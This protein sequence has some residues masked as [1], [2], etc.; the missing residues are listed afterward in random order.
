MSQPCRSM[1]LYGHSLE[2]GVPGW[3]GYPLATLM[4]PLQ[5]RWSCRRC[6]CLRCW[7]SYTMLQQVGIWAYKFYWPGW[8]RDVRQWCRECADCASRKMHGPAP[9]AP[10]QS[11]VTSRPYERV[12]LDILGPLPET[13][14]KNRY[15]LVV[16]DYF[17]RW[18]EA[19]PIPNQE[20]HTIAKVVVEQ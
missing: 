12:A 11:V 8:F 20:A 9:C 17:S 7:F 19:F 5:C 4:Q 13:A 18:T 2:S 10:L 16:G 1:R 14:N 6:W 15:I 3:S